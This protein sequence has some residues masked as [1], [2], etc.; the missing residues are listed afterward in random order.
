MDAT[1][2]PAV[3]ISVSDDGPGIREEFLPRAFEK[4]EKDSR[5]SGTGL[6]LYMAK[7]MAEAM[8]A[9]LLVWT[10]SEGTTITIALPVARIDAAVGV[11]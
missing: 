11:A 10:S 9:S 6:G 4:F 7:L 2:D 8:S 3:F 5:S 1:P